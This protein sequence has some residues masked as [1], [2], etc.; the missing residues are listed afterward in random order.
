MPLPAARRIAAACSAWSGSGWSGSPSESGPPLAAHGLGGGAERASVQRLD[1]PAGRRRPAAA[2][3]GG[4]RR[5]RRA[6]RVGPGGRAALPRGRGGRRRRHRLRP[7]STRRAGSA[8]RRR[9]ASSVPRPTRPWSRPCGSGASA[10][11]GGQGRRHRHPLPPGGHRP[12]RRAGPR[13]DGRGVAGQPPGRPLAGRGRPGVGPRRPARR[14]PRPRGGDRLG[15]APARLRP[16][17]AASLQVGAELYGPADLAELPCRE[18]GR[19]TVAD[20]EGST[21][22]SSRRPMSPPSA[23]GRLLGPAGAGPGPAPRFHV[24]VG[25]LGDAWRVLGTDPDKAR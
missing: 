25:P 8:T 7:C 21:P 3:P 2:T 18:R 11:R 1:L 15:P 13:P 6:R 9:P 19:W 10:S 20:P 16:P 14:R 4:D 22:P 5:R 23:R 17:G 24:V 12:V